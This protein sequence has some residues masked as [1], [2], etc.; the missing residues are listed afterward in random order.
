MPAGQKAR[1]G[2][3]RALLRQGLEDRA[4]TAALQLRREVPDKA[5][6]SFLTTSLLPQQ[7]GP[8]LQNCDTAEQTL[9]IES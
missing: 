8:W 7:S 3:P 5:L 4:Q 1:H 9:N 6:C 2:T